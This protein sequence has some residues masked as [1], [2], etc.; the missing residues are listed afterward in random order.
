MLSNLPNPLHHPVLVL[1]SSL[2]FRRVFAA[3]SRTC[4]GDIRPGVRP[5]RG[6]QGFAGAPP[7]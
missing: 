1:L 7:I 3:P 4:F 2:C 5:D 6:S